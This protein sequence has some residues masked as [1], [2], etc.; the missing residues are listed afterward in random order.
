MQGVDQLPVW[1][2]QAEQARDHAIVENRHQPTAIHLRTYIDDRYKL[3]IYRDRSWGELFDLHEDPDELRNR[4]DDPDYATVRARLFEQL[5]QA[6]LQ[7]EP[8]A[9]RRIAVA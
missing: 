8:L 2:G 3:T 4:F 6:E 9:Q 7:R 5:A 1:T